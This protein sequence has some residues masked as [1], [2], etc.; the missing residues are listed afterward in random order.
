LHPRSA[1]VIDDQDALLP[2][3][4]AVWF[5][6]KGQRYDVARIYSPQGRFRGYYVDA[7]EPV[8]WQDSDPLS[9][10]ALVDLYLDMWIWP[11]LAYSILDEDELEAARE[12][13][14]ITS[15]QADTA[16]DTMRSI[17]ARIAAHD[18]PPPPVLDF[19]LEAA[20]DQALIS[21]QALT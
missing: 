8:H 13:G 17:A 20:V 1:L 3:D 18:F 11:D 7:L 14:H 6:F 12:A 15:T 19:D 2:G 10:E 5:L 9:L 4:F 16:W 21:G